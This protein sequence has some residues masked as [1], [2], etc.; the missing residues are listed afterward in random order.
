M[1]R[2]TLSGQEKRAGQT[3]TGGTRMMASHAAGPVCPPLVAERLRALKLAR[4]SI[5]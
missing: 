3:H 5:R 1:D 2:R 4:L